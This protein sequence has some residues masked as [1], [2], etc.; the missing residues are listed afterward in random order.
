[1]NEKDLQ[2]LLTIR[3]EGN[4][5]KAAEKLFL[6]QPSLTYRIKSMEADLGV[7]LFIRTKKGVLL[8]PQCE[9]LIDFLSDAQFQMQNL[10]EELSLMSVSEQ[11]LIHVGGSLAFS[12]YELPEILKSFCQIYPNIKI[13]VTADISS[14]ILYLL[15]TGKIGVGFIR[16]DYYWQGE[17]VELKK[18]PLCLTSSIEL[19]FDELDSFP[20]IKY[21]A[22]SCL[23]HQI[24]QWLYERLYHEPTAS[25]MTNSMY[26]CLELIKSGMGWSILP[27]MGLKGFDGIKIPLYWSNNE[28][29]TRTSF[30]F[31]RTQALSLVPTQIFINYVKNYYQ[32]NN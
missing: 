23:R 6:S 15:Q 11:G 13:I 19:S 12:N 21:E 18:E 31:Y 14:K 32:I 2:L 17:K 7:T 25:I 5:T 3:N 22:D 20:Y 16:G 29:F 1:M 4:L 26:T 24:D 30:M 27:E 9:R 10:K 28:P 8:T